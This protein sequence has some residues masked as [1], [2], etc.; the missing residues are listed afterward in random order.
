ML[1]DKKISDPGVHG[2]SQFLERLLIAPVPH[3]ETFFFRMDQAGFA[4]NRHVMRDGWLR[5]LHLLLDVTGTHAFAFANGAAALLLEQA[6]DL[7]ASGIGN[8]LQGVNQ[9]FVSE[10]GHT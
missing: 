10:C 6:Q 2:L 5:E 8:G 9:L 7:E 4:Q 1:R 3:P